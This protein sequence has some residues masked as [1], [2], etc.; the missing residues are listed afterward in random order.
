MKIL[1]A[2]LI[3]CGLITALVFMLSSM[4][5]KAGDQ[6]NRES[7]KYK[8]HIGEKFILDNDTLTIVDY[9]LLNETFILSNKT[10]V[11]SKLILETKPTE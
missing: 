2:F 10:E 3:M 11:N 6:I 7:E 4:L 5:S 8:K 1:T 9:S